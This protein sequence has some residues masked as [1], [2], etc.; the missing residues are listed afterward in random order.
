[1]EAIRTESPDKFSL[2]EQVNRLK[3]ACQ[4]HPMPSLEQR[5][6]RLSALK[7]ALLAHKQ[8]LCDALALDYGQRSDYDSLVADILPC[9][10]QINYSLKRLKGWMRPAR[11]H[12]G[13]LLAPAR[14]EVHYQPL[15]VIGIMVPW[16]FP[17]MLSLGP[18]IGA[19]AAGN[20]AMIKLSEFTPHTNTLLRTLLA[21]V[22]GDDEVVVIEGDAGLAAAFS[23]LPFDHLLFTGSTAVGRLVMAAAAPQLTPLTLELGGK[24]PCLIAPDMPLALAVERMIFGKSLNAGQICVA[25]DYVLLPRGQE[26]AFIEAYQAHFRRLYPMGLD[27]PDYGSIINRA[28]Y[29]RLTAWLAEAKQAG[30]QVHPCASP[31]RDDGARRLVPHLLTEVPGHCQLMQQEIFGPLLPLVPY[32]S[33]EEAI[34]YVAARPRP[35]ACYLMSLD[36][37]LQSRLIRETHAGGMAINE[38]LF[39]V[40]ADD[41]PFGGIGPSGMGHYHGHEGFLTFSKAKTVLRRGRFSAGTLI[42]P[43]YRRWYQRLMMALF[44]R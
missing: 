26:Q 24:S 17:V 5:R 25:P 39:Q 28:Q 2:P 19:I 23:T 9:V 27:S 10:M 33:I 14:V 40:A 1:M 22:F 15:G 4:A 29:E 35:L 30:A 36:P 8:P 6:N 7:G 41:A 11:R 43:P 34:A 16:N 20:R 3:Q 12:P 13:L 21:Q 18:L 37:A 32:D 44:L 42:H 38:C 31:A